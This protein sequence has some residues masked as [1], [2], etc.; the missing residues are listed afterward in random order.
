M[1][2]ND[3][4]ENH[5]DF[6]EQVPFHCT[7]DD[8]NEAEQRKEEGLDDEQAEE[9]GDWGDVDPAGGEAPTAPGSAV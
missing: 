4:E 9:G 3:Q 6:N 5:N 8:R 7:A 1:N 2:K